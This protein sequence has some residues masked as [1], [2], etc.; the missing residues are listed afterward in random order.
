MPTAT[1]SEPRAAQDHPPVLVEITDKVA[2]LTLDRPAAR[3]ALSPAVRHKQHPHRSVALHLLITSP[4]H[5]MLPIVR[6]LVVNSL[7]YL[8]GQ[9]SPVAHQTKD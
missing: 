4:L 7:K 8:I 1:A 3:N 2:I 6:V 5:K 9:L